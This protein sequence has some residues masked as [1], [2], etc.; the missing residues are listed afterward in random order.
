MLH[1]QHL[2]WFPLIFSCWHWAIPSVQECVDQAIPAKPQ[3][4]YRG[5]SF[6]PV[7]CEEGK[8]FLL[9][10]TVLKQRFLI[11]DAVNQQKEMTN[12]WAIESESREGGAWEVSSKF[13][14]VLFALVMSF[15][16]PRFWKG[17]LQVLVHVK[18]TWRA[19]L[20]QVWLIPMTRFSVSLEWIPESASLTG[21][22]I[23]LLEFWIF[24]K[25]PSRLKSQVLC[26]C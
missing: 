19:H 20:R 1:L 15:G 18:I 16:G 5:K 24:P 4:P 10:L 6:V 9:P 23:Q 7:L 21:S 26:V 3:Q 22:Q 11:P 14:K 25:A 2:L 13:S 17:H 8:S 12:Y